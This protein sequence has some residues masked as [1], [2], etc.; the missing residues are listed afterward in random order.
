MK[1]AFK[2][3]AENSGTP[4]KPPSFAQRARQQLRQRW[5]AIRVQLVITLD[6]DRA[7]TTASCLANSAQERLHET[8]G[9]LRAVARAAP[10]AALR[11]ATGLRQMLADSTARAIEIGKGNAAKLREQGLRAYAGETLTVGREIALQTRD[12]LSQAAL[13]TASLA[14]AKADTLGKATYT[15]VRSGRFQATAAG[16][17]GGATALGASG[18]ATGLAGG[19]AVGT[20]VGSFG[21]LAQLNVYRFR[22]SVRIG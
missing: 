1:A 20:A 11:R 7:L 19:L 18:G 9:R 10:A 16:A 14:K 5:A 3:A 17:L 2:A 12:R 21:N 6:T 15:K 8:C 22:L 4:P 13:D